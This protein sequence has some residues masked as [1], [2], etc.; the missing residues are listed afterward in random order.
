L[1]RERSKAVGSV[2]T[3]AP[4]DSAANLV[5]HGSLVEAWRWL[6]FSFGMLD[7]WGRKFEECMASSYIVGRSG[8]PD[9]VDSNGKDVDL[10]LA[11]SQYDEL[12]YLRR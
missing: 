8:N 3:N 1:E 2:V 4:S 9:D 7:S 10:E 12:C 11:L 6:R 5:S